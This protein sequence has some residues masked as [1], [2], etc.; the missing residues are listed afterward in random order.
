MSYKKN[1][2]IYCFVLENHAPEHA[3]E[4][5]LSSVFTIC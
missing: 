2:N 4:G 5:E 1:N 3:L